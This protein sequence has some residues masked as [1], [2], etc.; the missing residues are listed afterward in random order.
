[1]N[2]RFLVGI[3]IL[4]GWSFEGSAWSA[5]WTAEVS[6][7]RP[8]F[9]RYQGLRVWMEG[10]KRRAEHEDPL[11]RR[12]IVS[13]GQKAYRFL[14]AAKSAQA[15]PLDNHMIPSPWKSEVHQT[16]GAVTPLGVEKV[17]GLECRV[18]TF[19]TESGN[20]GDARR[21]Q[22][23][24]WIWPEMDV[25]VKR[26]ETLGD[27]V[28]RTVLRNV[29]RVERFEEVLF[30][31]PAGM[32]VFERYPKPAPKDFLLGRPLADF[33]MGVFDHAGETLTR[34]K[35]L[36]GR[37]AVVINFFAT[38]CKA[39][40]FETP[41]VVAAYKKYQ[42]QGV[43]FV[44]IDVWSPD[45][46]DAKLRRY[47]TEYGISWPVL[48]DKEELYFQ[49]TRGIPVNMV[50]DAQGRIRA[51]KLGV[52]DAKWFEPVLDTLLKDHQKSEGGGHEP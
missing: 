43:A 28:H 32:S 17:D 47:V 37:K 33:S 35:L 5:G 2:N 29:K 52:V 18:H 8:Y 14:A 48:L 22:V 4:A 30:T 41:E 13:D 49:Y 7:T 27:R 45:E 36:E 1:M 16:L 40:L 23:K 3:I 31:L 46:T 6:D 19:Q 9:T 24:E 25:V 44:T 11:G 42:P 38:W 51:H 39:C 10:A 50:V 21:T 12:V 15:I 26:E 20:M 34:A